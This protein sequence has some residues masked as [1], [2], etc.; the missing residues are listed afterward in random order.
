MVALR[1]NQIESIW[2]NEALAQKKVD[3]ELYEIAEVF[4][5]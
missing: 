1:S 5:G 3:M 4:F 2:I